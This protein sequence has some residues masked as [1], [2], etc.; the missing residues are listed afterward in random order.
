MSSKQFQSTRLFG[1]NVADGHTVRA[2]K[3]VGGD[4]DADH[5]LNL[6][7]LMA[8]ADALGVPGPLRRLAD[9]TDADAPIGSEKLLAVLARLQAFDGTDFNRLRSVSAAVQALVADKTG[10]IVTAKASDWAI[11]HRPAAVTQPTVSRAGVANAR[12]VCT[13]IQASFFTGAN[14]GDATAIT[15]PQVVVLRD[16]ATGVGAV[17]WSGFVGT[18]ASSRS[19]QT[20]NLT[21]LSIV[22]TAGAAMT[23]E[24]TAVPAGVTNTAQVSLQG[25]TAQA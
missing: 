16:G 19:N 13:G 25:Y 1:V 15:V 21:G 11:E 10:V 17:L 24:F 4:V 20:L 14:A 7:M 18:G 5:I 6:R 2:I 12:H 3:E 22:G 23:L 9:G 8:A